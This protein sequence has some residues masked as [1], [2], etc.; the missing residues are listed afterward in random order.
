MKYETKE[1]ESANGCINTAYQE[2][3]FT[4][5][6]DRFPDKRGINIL[7]KVLNFIQLLNATD[8]ALVSNLARLIVRA[9]KI[10]FLLT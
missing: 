1:R 5:Q 10:A 8:S 4:I 2:R 3:I 9:K 6:L 7:V